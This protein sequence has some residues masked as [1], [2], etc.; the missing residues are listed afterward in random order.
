MS[1]CFLMQ[2]W[3]FRARNSNKAG[4]SLLDDRRKSAVSAE[5]GGPKA[6]VDLRAQL[7]STDARDRWV[8]GRC[9]HLG[10]AQ[11]GLE[12]TGRKARVQVG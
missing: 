12:Q 2:N 9:R 1:G 11:V 3:R 10:V 6:G 4:F 5:L 8:V 7:A